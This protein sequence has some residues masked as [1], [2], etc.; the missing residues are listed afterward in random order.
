MRSPAP[1]NC[2]SVENSTFVEVKSLQNVLAYSGRFVDFIASIKL[3]GKMQFN[4]RILLLR[5]L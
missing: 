1:L 5:H 4:R 3:R 2:F